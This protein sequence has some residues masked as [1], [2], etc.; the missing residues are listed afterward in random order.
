MVSITNRYLNAIV[1][2]AMTILVVAVIGWSMGSAVIHHY[3][4]DLIYCTERYLYLVGLFSNM[5]TEEDITVVPRLLDSDKKRC[6]ER[7]TE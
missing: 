2:A 6:H 4:G 1:G 3:Q 7:V 5:T